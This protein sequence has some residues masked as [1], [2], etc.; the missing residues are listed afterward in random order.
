[1]EAQDRRFDLVRAGLLDK[2]ERFVD[3]WVDG[4]FTA[5]VTVEA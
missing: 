5:L 1:M 2:R 4:V 3:Q